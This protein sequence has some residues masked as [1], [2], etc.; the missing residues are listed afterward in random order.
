[1]SRKRS[2]IAGGTDY[3][4]YTLDVILDDLVSLRDFTRESITKLKSFAKNVKRQDAKIEGSDYVIGYINFFIDLFQRY[5]GDFERLIRELPEGVRP[6]HIEIVDQIHQ[7]S[8]FEEQRCIKFKYDYV[9]NQGEE[10]LSSLLSSIYYYSRQLLIDYKD[11][12]NLNLRLK[13]FVS[14]GEPQPSH[15][16]ALKSIELKP[17][18]YG[19]GINFNHIIGRMRNV[20]PKKQ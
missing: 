13:T 7:S 9:E 11:L 17:N 2:F 8:V 5:L 10:Q 15:E 6:R 19:I 14:T 3:T 4:G 12:S 18:F 16:E 1:M 20:F